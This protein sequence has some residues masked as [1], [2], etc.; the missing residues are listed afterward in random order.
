MDKTELSDGT[1]T[2]FPPELVAQ[3]RKDGIV[4]ITTTVHDN[5]LMFIKVNYFIDASFTDMKAVNDAELLFRQKHLRAARAFQKAYT[6]L[7]KSI[8][9]AHQLLPPDTPRAAYRMRL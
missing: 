7:R 9:S 3:A 6:R 1:V 2:D 5:Y 4:F 8:Y